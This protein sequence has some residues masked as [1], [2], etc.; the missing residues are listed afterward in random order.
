MSNVSNH[1]I[2]LV[3]IGSNKLQID[4]ITNS[5]YIIDPIFLVEWVEYF[6]VKGI[7]AYKA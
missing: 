2:A 7:G 4:T 3:N 1:K 6:K 5:A